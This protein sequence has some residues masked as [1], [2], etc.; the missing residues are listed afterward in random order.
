[1][2]LSPHNFVSVN[3]ILADVLK[4]VKDSSFKLNSKGWY[5]SQIQQALEELSFNTFFNDVNQ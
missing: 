4:I 2:D 1:M 5:T 3:E